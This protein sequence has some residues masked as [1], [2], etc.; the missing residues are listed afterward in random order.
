MFYTSLAVEKCQRRQWEQNVTLT[1]MVRCQDHN[2]NIIM[3]RN[4]N[5]KY[6]SELILTCR[7]TKSNMKNKM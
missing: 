3:H 7:P 1:F 5:D 4:F 6:R 2:A